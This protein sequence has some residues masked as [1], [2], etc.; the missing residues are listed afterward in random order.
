MMFTRN[1]IHP[2]DFMQDIE[3][4]KKDLS[5]SAKCQLDLWLLDVGLKPEVE[6][7]KDIKA[8]LA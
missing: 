3:E 8:A 7:M 4:I 5:A 1:L 6:V 2:I